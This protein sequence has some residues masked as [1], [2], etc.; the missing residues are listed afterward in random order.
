[1]RERFA[2]APFDVGEMIAAYHDYDR[3]VNAGRGQ[4]VS[5]DSGKLGWGEANFLDAYVK[6][7][8]VTGDRGWLDRVA[9]HAERILSG[10]LDWFEDGHPTWVTPTYSVAWMRCEPLHNR[11]TASVGPVD[12]RVWTI[13]GGSGAEDAEF[14]FEIT[15]RGRYELRRWP[16]RE[17]V[18]SGPWRSGMPIDDLAPL[19]F[20]VS[21]RARVGDRFRIETFAPR[22]LEYIVHQGQLFYPLARFCEMV[23]GRRDLKPAFGTVARQ[24]AGVVGDLVE[25]HERDWL[26]TGRGAGAY[27]FTCSGSERYPNRILPHN[28]YLA[29]GRVCLAMSGASR[30]RR[31]IERAEAMA[32]NFKRDL[33]RA[34]NAWE[35]HYWDWIEAGEPGH[36]AVEDTSHGHIDI[37]FAVEACRRGVLFSD[38]DLTRFARTLLGVMW[39]GDPE[40]VRIGGRVDTREGDARVF[41]DW[42]DLVQWEPRVWDVMWRLYEQTER[43]APWAPTM[44]R[45]WLRRSDLRPGARR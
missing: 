8:E 6:L 21:G 34:G 18:G 42:V 39:N 32:R 13:R 4:S 30:K 14:I 19:R 45:G 31:F 3:G 17:R 27:R 12:G 5:S 22:P 28:Q 44:L 29:L 41:I 36:S 26:D 35:W 23:Q 38:A 11:G 40:S 43:P 10:R 7:F 20:A 33:R 1:M 9:A 25:K 15:G 2:G 37:G 24:I 16:S